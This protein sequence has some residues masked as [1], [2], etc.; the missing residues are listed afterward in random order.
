MSPSHTVW[1][2]SSVF[3]VQRTEICRVNLLFTLSGSGFAGFS[4]P[5]QCS[6]FPLTL[7]A[8]TILAVTPAVAER[9]I[10]AGSS[11]QSGS[12]V[13]VTASARIVSGEAI[14]FGSEEQRD[15]AKPRLKNHVAPMAWTRGEITLDDQQRV[16]LTEFH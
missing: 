11:V 1:L 5:M 3:W 7:L 9:A 15:A 10:P 12:R 8:A 16:G 13:Q 4:W 6:L 2:V 14:Y